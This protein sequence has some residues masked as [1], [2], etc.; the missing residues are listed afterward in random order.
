MANILIVDDQTS[1][2]ELIADT[3]IREGFDVQQAASGKIAIEIAAHQPPDLIICDIGMPGLSGYDVLTTL[4]QHAATSLIPFIFL[5]ACDDAQSLRRGMAMGADDYLVKPFTA[6][7]LIQTINARIKRQT[8]VQAASE[9]KLSTLRHSLTLAFPHE[10]K[11]PLHGIH[12]FAQLLK[13]GAIANDPDKVRD[14][15][16]QILT[17]AERLEGLIENFLLYGELTQI[18]PG[19]TRMA[20]LQSVDA[21]SLASLLKDILKRKAEQYNHRNTYQLHL[22]AKL[23]FIGSYFVV[24]KIAEEVIDNGFKFSDPSTP[25]V[26]SATVTRS[27]P[28]D[29]D[30]LTLEVTNQG[31]G[32]TPS[33]IDA[34]GA[35]RQFHRELYEQ[36]GMGLGLAIVNRLV[37]LQGGRLQ[38][39][40]APGQLSVRINLPQRALRQAVST[41]DA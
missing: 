21:I 5:T 35:Y 28:S 36:Q 12:G 14:I 4:R 7:D 23:I 41:E 40:S 26:I 24:S 13:L 22:P 33:E 38:I 31:R 15:A 19:S 30:Q 6:K 2:R 34:I 20:T 9:A 16:T 37:E 10:L 1:A 18:L 8:Q 17:S 11:T 3:L 39:S 27:A 32:M 29:S 25:I